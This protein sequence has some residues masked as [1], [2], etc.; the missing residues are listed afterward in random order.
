MCRLADRVWPESSYGAHFD[1][2]PAMVAAF[3][4]RLE[5]SDEVA[6][7]STTQ[8]VAAE[9]SEQM[10]MLYVFIGVLLIFGS[11]LAGSA[12]H[13]VAMV[14]LLERTRE[15]AT[16]CSLGFSAWTAAG[17]AGLEVLAL[18]A[19]STLIGWQGLRRLDLA[20]ATKSHE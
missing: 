14:S 4:Q 20:Q 3:R 6:L 16:L 11:V 10:A 12:L 13:S 7:V 1:C 18:A 15:L 19:G 17:L 8:D 2:D 5:R 9:I